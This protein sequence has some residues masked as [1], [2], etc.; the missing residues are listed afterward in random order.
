MIRKL[1]VPLK[2]TPYLRNEIRHEN[3]SIIVGKKKK[4]DSSDQESSYG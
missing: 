3:Y 4:K 1:Q 2:I